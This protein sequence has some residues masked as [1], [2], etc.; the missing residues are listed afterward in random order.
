LGSSLL[1]ESEA[2]KNVNYLASLDFII[3]LGFGLIFPLFPVYATNLGAGA[4]EIGI[5]FSSFVLTRAI[6]STTFGNLSDTIGRKRLILVGSSLYVVF[7]ILFTIPESWTG[8]VIVRGFQGVASAMVWPVSEALV[9]D[10]TPPKERGAAM[11]KIVMSSNLG[12]VVGPFLGGGLVALARYTLGFSEEEALVQGYSPS[13]GSGPR[14][15]QEPQGAVPERGDGRVR[16]LQH[17]SADGA[18]PVG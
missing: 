5:I 12:F 1:T 3:S 18:V 16:V 15:R 8:L 2:R 13:G 9:I 14:D 4:L 17:R 6:F 11:G 10:S 7:A